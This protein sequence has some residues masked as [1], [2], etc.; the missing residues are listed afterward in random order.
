MDFIFPSENLITRRDVQLRVESI[1]E[2]SELGGSKLHIPKIYFWCM[3]M[4]NFD[5]I[6]TSTQIVKVIGNKTIC[7]RKKK[8]VC[9]RACEFRASSASTA[10][11]RSFSYETRLQP[12]T[13]DA[14]VELSGWG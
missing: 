7:I 8:S 14:I 2:D 12:N 9:A 13:R 1:P 10:H 5:I 11:V 6:N 4:Y 3:G